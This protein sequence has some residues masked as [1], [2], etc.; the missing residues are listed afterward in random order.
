MP[1]PLLQLTLFDFDLVRRRDRKF[2]EAAYDCGL[3][4]CPQAAFRFARIW[5][6]MGWILSS[7]RSAR[8][9]LFCS[10]SSIC[11]IFA[12]RSYRKPR[13]PGSLRLASWL[14]FVRG[15]AGDGSTISCAVVR[16]S[17]SRS[18]RASSSRARYRRLL[19]FLVISSRKVISR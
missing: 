3:E 17:A 11:L 14:N 5:A 13:S 9:R 18:R 12:Q 19:G 16:F 15:D 7:C 10:S 2:D 4:V 6:V 8:S 1:S